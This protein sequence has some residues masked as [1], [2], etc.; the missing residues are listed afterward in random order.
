MG[1]ARSWSSIAEVYPA[2][3]REQPHGYVPHRSTSNLWR[4]LQWPHLD[5]TVCDRTRG[6]GDEADCLFESGR[7]DDRE[8]GNWKI[9]AQEWSF[10]GIHPCPVGITHLHGLTGDTHQRSPRA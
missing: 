3:M 5:D 10:A 7:L 2:L 6:L 1:F 8:S 4:R 9:R